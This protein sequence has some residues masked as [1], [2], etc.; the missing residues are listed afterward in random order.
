MKIGF[1]FMIG[2]AF[3]PAAYMGVFQSKFFLLILG[4]LL[5]GA[6]IKVGKVRCTTCASTLD[7]KRVHDSILN[8]HSRNS[9]DSGAVS[10]HTNHAEV[11]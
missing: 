8:S 10:I 2:M 6:A 7:N 1:V 5:I 9:L 3:L 4:L 11:L